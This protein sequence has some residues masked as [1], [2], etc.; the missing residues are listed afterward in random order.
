MSLVARLAALV[1]AGQLTAE[2]VLHYAN[3]PDRLLS[4]EERRDLGS[5]VADMTDSSLEAALME[6]SSSAMT[7]VMPRMKHD[8]RLD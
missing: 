5:L 4:A 8:S 1:D 7:Q 3:Y 6:P 2:D